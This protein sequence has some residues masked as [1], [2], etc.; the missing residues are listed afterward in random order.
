MSPIEVKRDRAIFLLGQKMNPRVVKEF[1]DILATLV[2]A[3]KSSMDSDTR[4]EAGAALAAI[5][6]AIKESR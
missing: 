6:K 1:S 5:D 3:S 4:D 2:S